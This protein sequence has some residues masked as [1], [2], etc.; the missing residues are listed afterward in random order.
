MESDLILL[1]IAGIED[2]LREGVQEA[3][4]ICQGAGITVRMITGDNKETAI[5]IAKKCGILPLN[6]ADDIEHALVLSGEQFRNQIGNLIPDPNNP[7]ES[8]I[9]NIEQFKKITKKMRVLY[10][11]SPNDKLLLVTGLKQLN[12]VVAVTGDGS[13][14][15]PALRKSN[16]GFAM[17]LA[18]T[19]LAQEASDIILLDDN[20]S[21]IIVA[22]SWGR[23]I[24]DSIS[25]FIQF[26]LTI[27]A[28]ALNLCF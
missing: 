25:K 4:S 16:V 10:R 24:Y 17:H 26:Q 3:V 11:S 6:M 9:Q 27:N 19:Q 23:N 5:A 21:S 22:I 20:F 8:I 7:K 15:A 2:P 1:G 18:G 13:N 28:V 14:D 12:E